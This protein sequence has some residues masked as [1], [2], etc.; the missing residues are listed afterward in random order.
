MQISRSRA[1]SDH[2]RSFSSEKLTVVLLPYYNFEIQNLVNLC[3]LKKSWL[4][5]LLFCRFC[6]VCSIFFLNHK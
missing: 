4:N 6:Y 5:I 3:L 1:Q 2:D